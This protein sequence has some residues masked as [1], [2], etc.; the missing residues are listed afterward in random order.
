MQ[1]TESNLPQMPFPTRLDLILLVAMNAIKEATKVYRVIEFLVRD[2]SWPEIRLISTSCTSLH[3]L[4]M[5]AASV[6]GE[7]LYS[8]LGSG[9]DGA[10]C[11]LEE[12]LLYFETTHCSGTCMGL[13]TAFYWG[14][15]SWRIAAHKTA[16]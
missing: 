11:S 2:P 10:R 16:S 14:P 3:S 13:R 1:E 4:Q 8:C 15:E 7:I 6:R 9:D 12:L 5:T